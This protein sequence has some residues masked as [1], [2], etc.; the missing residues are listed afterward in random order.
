MEHDKK[1]YFSDTM[2]LF[3]IF[4]NLSIFDQSSEHEV[5]C[6]MAIPYLLKKKNYCINSRN[7]RNAYN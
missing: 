2:I 4:R 5:G 7:M 1:R 6:K 3:K